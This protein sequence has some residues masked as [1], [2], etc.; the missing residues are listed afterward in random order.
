MPDLRQQLR[1]CLEGRVCFIGVGNEAWGDDGLGL[2]LAES[3]ANWLARAEAQSNPLTRN[4]PSVSVVNAGASPERWLHFLET[5]MFDHVIFLDAVEFG[6][7]PGSVVLLDAQEMIARF[8]LVSTHKLS[9]G[10]LARLIETG[11]RTHAWLLGVQPR[12]LKPDQELTSNVQETLEIVAEL[13]SDI[14]ETVG[15]LQPPL[16][17]A[18]LPLSLETEYGGETVEQQPAN[19]LVVLRGAQIRGGK[20]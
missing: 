13:V 12:A 19:G 6:G 3:L 4:H 5:Q 7:A 1:H 20:R 16:E 2:R 9:L 11:G 18:E 10:L 8:P 17:R 15:S 14:L